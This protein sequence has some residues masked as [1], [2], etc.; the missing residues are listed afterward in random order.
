MLFFKTIAH[1]TAGEETTKYPLD[2][3]DKVKCFSKSD[4]LHQSAFFFFSDRYLHPL[5]SKDN[6]GSM[7]SYQLPSALPTQQDTDASTHLNMQ[8]FF[9]LYVVPAINLCNKMVKYNTG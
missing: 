4:Q 9:L 6:T 8:R 7:Y 2:H 3:L 1:M 5:T